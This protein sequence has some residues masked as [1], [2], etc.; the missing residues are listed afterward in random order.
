MLVPVV[1]K[2]GKEE[3]VSKDELQYMMVT[4]KVLF[5]KRSNGWAVVGRDPLRQG[6]KPYAGG[7]R[8]EHTVFAQGQ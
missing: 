6:N 2:D 1:T 7:D 8:R 3:L 4:E 5:F